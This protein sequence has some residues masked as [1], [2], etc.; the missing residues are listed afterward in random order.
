MTDTSYLLQYFIEHSPKEKEQDKAKSTPAPKPAPVKKTD[1]KH[2]A[3]TTSI[4][5]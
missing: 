1:G 4:I 2:C 3:E 5:R